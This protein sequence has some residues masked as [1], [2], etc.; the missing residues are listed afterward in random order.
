MTD[1][2]VNETCTDDDSP[3][4]ECIADVAVPQILP[5]DTQNVLTGILAEPNPYMAA[6]GIFV[7]GPFADADGA[8]VDAERQRGRD[9][10]AGEAGE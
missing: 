10:A 7:G 9:E 3:S 8:Y 4:I 5:N 1:T 6:A 2:I